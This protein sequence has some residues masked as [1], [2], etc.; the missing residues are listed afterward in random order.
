MGEHEQDELRRDLAASVEA[1]RELGPAYEDDLVRSFVE[2]L[3]STIREQVDA[4]VA[5][6]PGGDAGNREQLVLGLVS[7]GTGIPVTAI[8]GGTGG[9]AGIIV[10]W[11]GIAGV[12]AAYAWGRPGR[13]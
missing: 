9:T 4:Q 8:A 2:R 11:A 3:D 1:R 13:R 12:N 10:A 7:L 5:R 6:R